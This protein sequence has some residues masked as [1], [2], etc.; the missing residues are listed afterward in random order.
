[1]YSEVGT[2]LVCRAMLGLLVLAHANPVIFFI[3]FEPIRNVYTC[4]Y[5]VLYANYMKSSAKSYFS[6]LAQP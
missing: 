1:M 4:K 2:D 6:K 5:F 3:K